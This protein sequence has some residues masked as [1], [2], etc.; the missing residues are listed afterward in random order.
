MPIVINLSIYLSPGQGHS[1]H[2][3]IYGEMHAVI[4]TV[5]YVWN[6]ACSNIT[7]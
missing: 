6:N 7:Y 4:S 1:K 2:Y 5:S 3:H